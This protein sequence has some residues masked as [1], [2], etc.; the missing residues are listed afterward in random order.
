MGTYGYDKTFFDAAGIEF[1]ELTSNDN[2][3]RVLVVPAYQGRVMTS[4]SGG[5]KGSSYGWINHSLIESGET[6]PQFNL[7]KQR[8]SF[9]IM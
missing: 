1:L 7:L 3:S 5:A 6:D 8:Y 9:L 2:L 4:T